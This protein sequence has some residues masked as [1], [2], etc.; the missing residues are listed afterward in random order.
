VMLFA[1]KNK[2][3]TFERAMPKTFKEYLDTFMK[4]FL[5]DFTV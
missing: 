3:P 5:D 2:P 4:I 1:M